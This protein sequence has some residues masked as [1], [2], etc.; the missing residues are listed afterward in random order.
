MLSMIKDENLRL[1]AQRYLIN[2]Y[3]K[4]DQK[5]KLIASWNKLL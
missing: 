2:N 5:N 4:L 3:L 1:D